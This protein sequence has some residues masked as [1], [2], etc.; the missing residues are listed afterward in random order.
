MR[1]TPMAQTRTTPTMHEPMT[2]T[3]DHE[4]LT[5]NG[6][7]SE[8]PGSRGGIGDGDGAGEGNLVGCAG[9]GEWGEGRGVGTGVT[10]GGIGAGVAG[11]RGVGTGEPTPA[12]WSNGNNARIGLWKA[13]TLPPCTCLVQAGG[14]SI[15]SCVSMSPDSAAP[16]FAMIRSNVILEAYF[17][18]AQHVCC[19]LVPI[20]FWP[21]NL[22]SSAISVFILLLSQLVSAIKTTC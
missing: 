19:R 13:P 18:S 6:V 12:V 22:S 5:K 15:G 10:G 9:A 20:T 3:V 16:K 21:G 7:G 11:L 2:T 17:E 1:C 8:V 14:S 4:L